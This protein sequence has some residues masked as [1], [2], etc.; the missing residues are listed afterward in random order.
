MGAYLQMGLCQYKKNV[1]E[2]LPGYFSQ[3]CELELNPEFELGP[4]VILD[5]CE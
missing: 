5:F 3:E 2:I 4:E 1:N